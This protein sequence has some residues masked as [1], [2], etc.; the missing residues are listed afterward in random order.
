MK[1]NVFAENGTLC[2][3]PY[4]LSIRH[5]VAWPC[6]STPLAEYRA[7]NG[8]DQ[9]LPSRTHKA[10]EI[11]HGFPVGLKIKNKIK[12][13]KKRKTQKKK[14]CLRLQSP[15][16]M[17]SREMELGCH[18]WVDCLVA[19]LFW[20]VAFSDTVPVTL[21]RA[22]AERASCE[23]TSCLALAESPPWHCSGGG[24]K[25][26]RSLRSDH[27]DELFI[28]IRPSPPPQRPAC[29]PS[30]ISRMWRLWTLGTTKRSK[31]G[32]LT[33]DLHT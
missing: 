9:R 18:S 28:G 8:T 30:L 22:A 20:T 15:G 24:W 7:N 27:R 11:R 23:Y 26:I 19:G 4:P 21:F 14:K 10:E 5:R 3:Y 13:K 17:K 32:L 33:S 1:P 6:S 31:L 12:K 25:S 29:P 16:E 2:R